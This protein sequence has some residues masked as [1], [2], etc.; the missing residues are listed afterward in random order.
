[1]RRNRLHLA[2]DG[3]RKQIFLTTRLKWCWPFR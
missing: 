3:D 2:I 1:L